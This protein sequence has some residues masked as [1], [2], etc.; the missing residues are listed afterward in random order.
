MSLLTNVANA[1]RMTDEVWRRHANPW[2]VWTR[3][4]AIPLMILAIWSRVWL[5]WWCLAPVGAV[6]VWLWINPRAFPAVDNPT[7]WAARG[8]YGERLWLEKHGHVPPRYRAVFR[9][10]AVVATLGFALLVVGL[11]T[12]AI[13]PTLVGATCIVLGQLWRIDRLGKF[14]DE[15]QQQVL[16]NPDL[17]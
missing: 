8:I 10:V 6:L 15:H 1:F 5:G 2:S 3:F 12:L 9:L 17:R 13:W 14:F 7:S 4:A 11:A 16:D